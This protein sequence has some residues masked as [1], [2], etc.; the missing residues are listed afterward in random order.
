[1]HVTKKGETFLI[2]IP[3]TK[4]GETFL[5]Y[6]PILDAESFCHEISSPYKEFKDVFQKRML[7]PC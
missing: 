5:I 3:V 7:T 1:M 6:I 2:Y 4:K